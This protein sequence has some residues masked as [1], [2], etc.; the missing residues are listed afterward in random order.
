MPAHLAFRDR[1]S[2][3]ERERDGHVNILK[4]RLECKNKIESSPFS[5]L[6][7]SEN[8]ELN[9]FDSYRYL[10]LQPKNILLYIIGYTFLNGKENLLSIM[11]VYLLALCIYCNT[12]DNQY[13]LDIDWIDKQQTILLILRC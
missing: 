12:D 4:P 11:F 10:K 3:F 5:F 13:S 2:V 8:V 6:K 1:G 7:L 9:W